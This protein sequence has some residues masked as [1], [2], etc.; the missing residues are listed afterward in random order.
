MF[1]AA[2]ADSVFDPD[3]IS[4]NV[5]S[6]LLAGFFIL[7][8]AALILLLEALWIWWSAAHGSAARRISKRLR[9]MAAQGE[10]H[11]ER[12]DILKQRSYSRHALLEQLLRRYRTPAL[13]DRLLLQAGVPWSVAQTLAACWPCCWPVQLHPCCCNCPG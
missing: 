3:R 4:S 9:L 1:G 8:F 7:L 11:G 12:I 2:V 10:R 5:M 6:A 13:L